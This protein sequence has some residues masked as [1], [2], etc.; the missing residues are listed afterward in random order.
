MG[1]R[2]NTFVHVFELD[3][4]GRPDGRSGVFGPGD[5]LPDWAVASITNP[6]VWAGE[7]PPTP[8]PVIPADEP[9][10]T[11]ELDRLRARVAELEKS[12]SASTPDASESAPGAPPRGGP[13][14]GA[15]EWRAYARGVGVEVADDASRE[16]VIKALDA[17]DKPT[18]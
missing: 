18:E 13:G 16:D 4:K 1:Y 7:K 10:P 6:D 3:S 11:A 2:L 8:E 15:P 5:T 9:D 12:S 14:S 17:A